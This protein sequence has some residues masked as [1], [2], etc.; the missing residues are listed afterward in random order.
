MELSLLDCQGKLSEL[1]PQLD[2]S[3]PLSTPDLETRSLQG[4]VLP[5]F[6]RSFEDEF[7]LGFTRSGAFGSAPTSPAPVQIRSQD[8]DLRVIGRKHSLP[9]P[10]ELISHSYYGHLP[11]QQSPN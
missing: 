1:P 9:E 6:P 3:Y 2:S 7:W 11:K 5:L 10:T 4:S 8:D